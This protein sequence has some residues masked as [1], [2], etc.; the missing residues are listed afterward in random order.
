MSSPN[1]LLGLSVGTKDVEEERLSLIQMGHER[2]SANMIS[3]SHCVVLER[4]QPK[5]SFTI[6]M[7][8]F[9]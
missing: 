4:T 3:M 8:A 7:S 5:V 6:S 9:Q 2:A 1:G